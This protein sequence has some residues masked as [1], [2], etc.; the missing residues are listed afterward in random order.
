MNHLYDQARTSMESTVHLLAG[1]V[2]IND[3]TRE[4]ERLSGKNYV[5]KEWDE[6]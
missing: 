4:F 3:F 5:S 2:H 1:Q 6:M